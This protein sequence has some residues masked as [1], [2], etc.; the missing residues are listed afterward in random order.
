MNTLR[1]S[2]KH[3]ADKYQE[4]AKEML[5]SYHWSKD[6]EYFLA[7][8]EIA[9]FTVEQIRDLTWARVKD[10]YEGLLIQNQVV[11]LREKYMIGIREVLESRID[12]YG[13]EIDHESGSPLIFAKDT[14]KR[15][16]KELDQFKG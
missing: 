6:E 14:L 8:M 4:R 12:F 13:Q 7:L 3:R 9:Q 1:R 16:T 15:V 5:D 2:E 11:E 10:S